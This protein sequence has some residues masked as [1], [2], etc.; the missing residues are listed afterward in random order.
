MRQNLFRVV[1][2]LKPGE[3][4]CSDGYGNRHGECNRDRGTLFGGCVYG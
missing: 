2:R 4:G 3:S 1:M